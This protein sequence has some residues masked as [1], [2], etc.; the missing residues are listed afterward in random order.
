MMML[1]QDASHL[2]KD[3]RSMAN[4]HILNASSSLL[5]SILHTHSSTNTKRV[6]EG[7][8]ATQCY[9]T[10]CMV[11]KWVCALKKLVSFVRG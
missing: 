8:Y 9:A 7:S 5:P 1:F 2:A 4:A 3:A 10:Q 11:S 6:K